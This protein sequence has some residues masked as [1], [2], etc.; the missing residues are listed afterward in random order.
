MDRASENT[1]TVLS[2]T[3]VGINNNDIRPRS[4]PCSIKRTLTLCQK[5]N[6]NSEKP[7]FWLAERVITKSNL[8]CQK[9]E[10]TNNGSTTWTQHKDYLGEL[11]PENVEMI[12]QVQ[13]EVIGTSIPPHRPRLL[14]LHPWHVEVPRPGV[15][16]ELK[17]PAYVT[18]RA[19]WDLSHIY[20]LHHSSG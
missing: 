11:S 9:W 20:N 7:P 5:S 13:S 1:S 16:S 17:L 8:Y 3:K 14:G 19:M 15:Q 10:C 4:P 12:N 18:A 2:G 6:Y